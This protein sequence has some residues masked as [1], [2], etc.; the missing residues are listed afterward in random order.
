MKSWISVGIFPIKNIGKNI[1]IKF[2]EL[3][4]AFFFV[5]YGWARA[6]NKLKDGFDHL[7]RL[8]E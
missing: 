8:A 5:L 2:L 4:V 6:S 3:R 7:E 1:L